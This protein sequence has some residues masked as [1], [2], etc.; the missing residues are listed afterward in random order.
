MQR[1]AGLAE[2][3]RNS[4]VNSGKQFMENSTFVAFRGQDEGDKG[5]DPSCSGVNLKQEGV[6]FFMDS[7]VWCCCF[8]ISKIQTNRGE[9]YDAMWKIHLSNNTFMILFIIPYDKSYAGMSQQYK[10]INCNTLFKINYKM[11]IRKK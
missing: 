8:K 6:Y 1:S 10:A 5:Q 4:T 11:A 9:I 2:S 3:C 7:C